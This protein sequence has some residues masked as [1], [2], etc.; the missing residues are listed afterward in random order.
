MF[1]ILTRKTSFAVLLLLL[2]TFAL[3]F[4][5]YFSP[6]KDFF[7]ENVQ[8]K[9]TS[10]A[11]GE[12]V[13]WEEANRLLPKYG[14]CTIIDFETGQ[15]FRV[16][17]R[18]GSSHAD[19]QPL[20][21]NDTAVLK[22]IYGQ[23]SWNR[24][25]ALVKLDN[26]RILAASMNGMPHGAGAIKGNNFSGHFCLHFRDSRTHAS[27]S[28]DLAHQVMIW[29]A[30]GIFEEQ[31]ALQSPEES[32]RIFVTVLNQ[33]DYILAN[34][35]LCGG[36]LSEEK[37]LMFKSIKIEKLQRLG[38]NKYSLSLRTVRQGS[39]QSEK[40]QIEIDMAP[41]AYWRIHSSSLEKI[42]PDL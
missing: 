23:W 1:T 42:F 41:G 30:A 12:F 25:A 20:T 36:Q 19:V 10:Q 6:R 13:P 26:G 7:E 21:A 39:N 35:L 37:C 33:G 3:V 16:Q 18:A 11:Y 40:K 9:N 28:Q 27:G 34:R 38:G 14:K 8:P 29:K 24:R 5:L 4:W 31:M 22:S 15:Q 32:I 2:M 17:R